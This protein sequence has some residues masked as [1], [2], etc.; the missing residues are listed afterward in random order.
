MQLGIHKQS[1]KNIAAHE[2]SRGGLVLDGNPSFEFRSIA[3]LFGG[4]VRATVD[5][6]DRV[7]Q[8]P[9]AAD[10]AT[11]GRMLPELA[12]IFSI[13]TDRAV[14][15]RIDINSASEAV[16]ASIPGVSESLARSIRGLQPKP[17]ERRNKGFQSVAWILS[18]GLVTTGEFR[19]MA[20]YMTVD[21][22]VYSGIAIGQIQGERPVAA[23]RFS[24]DCTATVHRMLLFQDL[25]IFSAEQTGL[26]WQK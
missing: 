15:G 10:T 16:L 25:P 6:K 26:S 17:E 4:Q 13:S 12:E 19:A 3:D 9:W 20:P 11:I 7:I 23:I 24:V 21:G 22:D 5:G 14:Y 1:K 18:R 8:S 2:Y